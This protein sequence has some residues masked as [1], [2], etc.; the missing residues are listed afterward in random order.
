MDAIAKMWRE[1][2]LETIEAKPQDAPIMLSG[3]MDSACIV[4][5]CLALGRKP[6]CYTIQLGDAESKDLLSAK[7]IA[8]DANLNLH[9]EKIER[10]RE[11]LLKGINDSIRLFI[12]IIPE[13][14]LKPRKTLIQCAIPTLVIAN[15]VKKDGYSYLYA[16]THSIVEDT[17]ECYMA[18]NRNDLEKVQE[19]RK[20]ESISGSIVGT[21]T[22]GFGI[23]AASQGIHL[24]EPYSENPLRDVGLSISFKEMNSPFQKGIACRAFPES[25][26]YFNWRRSRNAS[27]QVESGIREWHDELL[28]DSLNFRK[29]KVVSVIYKD[30]ARQIMGLNL[31]FPL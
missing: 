15:R 31:N 13:L 22:W 7:K 17:K 27:F 25:M 2:F 10:S 29:A 4:A 11:N 28:K 30:M 26:Q 3:G 23:A 18:A 24:I 14:M 21:A 20:K 9:I 5:A 19:L 12:P 1:A 8:K 6:E 16:G